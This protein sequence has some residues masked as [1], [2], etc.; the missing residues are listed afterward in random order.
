MRISPSNLGSIAIDRHL[1]LISFDFEK[2][3]LVEALE[4]STVT[5]ILIDM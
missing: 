5:P 2:L 1:V 4:S 3:R